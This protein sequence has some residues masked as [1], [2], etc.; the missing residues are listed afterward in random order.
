MKKYIYTVFLFSLFYLN[1]F[2]Q[3][4]INEVMYAP[5]SPNKEWFEI[6]NTGNSS[7]N[8]QNWKWRDAAGS[9]PIRT[10]TTQ[11]ILINPNTFAI[12]CE[13]STNFRTAFPG[14]TGILI[15]SIGWNA[16]N[17]TGSE[18][19][20]L[21]YSTGQ[22]SDS[23]TYTNSWGGSGG[24]SLERINPLANTNLQ[25]NWGTSVDPNKATPDRTN[26]LT[27]KLNDLILSSFTVTP[28]AP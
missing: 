3:V 20:V 2:A 4:I 23:L 22:T 6:Y 27:P 11:S 7:I 1:T 21:Y 24:F 18:N 12:V 5:T 16:L 10:K 9:N 8:L 17:N 26:S 25:S 13:D 14:V 19:V 28:S 15:Q